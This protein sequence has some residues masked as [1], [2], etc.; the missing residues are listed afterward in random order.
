MLPSP[1][2]DAA[3]LVTGASSGIGA[4]IAREL[5]RRG[6]P[7][8]LVA[9]RGDALADLA[10][11][12]REL[13]GQD[14]EVHALDLGADADLAAAR[15][16]VEDDRVAGVVNA[17]GFGVTGRVAEIADQQDALDGLVRLNVLALHS[18]TVAAVGALVRRAAADGRPGAI[19]NVSSITAFQP[20]PG[21][22]S[23][24]ASKAFVQSFSEAVHTELS[25]SGVTLTT[26]SPGLTRT[27]FADA[28]GTDAFDRVPDLLVGEAADVAAAG[29]AAMVRGDR[30]V[31]PGLLNQLSALGGRLAPRTL[32]LPALDAGMDLYGA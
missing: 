26:V 15:A 5:A 8:L 4:A 30:S 27:G 22:A 19:L 7:T 3:V 20:L 13:S 18:L 10:A 32:L 28:A 25:G 14:A 21:A 11:E 29:V 6:H 9:R 16:L 12:L 31:T 23:Y 24:A 2:P 1:G 17:A